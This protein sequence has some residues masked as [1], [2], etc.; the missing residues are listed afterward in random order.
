MIVTSNKPFSRGARSSATTWPPPRWST[1]SSTTL[2]L[3]LKGDP[4]GSKTATSDPAPA[5]KAP[6]PADRHP[7]AHLAERRRTAYNATI[8]PAPVE[9]LKATTHESDANRRYLHPCGPTFNRR[10]RPNFR[11]ALTATRRVGRNADLGRPGA[12]R[13]H[14]A[15]GRPGRQAGSATGHGS[16][17]DLGTSRRTCQ[18]VSVLVVRVVVAWPGARSP[19]SR[20]PVARHRA[21]AAQPSPSVGHSLDDPKTRSAA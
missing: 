4:T 19:G 3:S 12:S 1:A 10:G 7:S 6:K 5:A 16:Q 17:A 8:S 2:N 13:A 15:S 21:G 9:A 11:P 14:W 18:R 20:R